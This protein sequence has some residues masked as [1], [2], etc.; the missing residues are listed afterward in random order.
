[1][2]SEWNALLHQLQRR[3]IRTIDVISILISD[4]IVLVGGYILI[5][6][7]ERFLRSGNRFIIGAREISGAAFMLIY[8]AW[9]FHDVWEFVKSS[10]E[11]G[12]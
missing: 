11:T 12:Q 2:S 3:L 7:A 8:V 6:V 1:V 9:V 4:A 10:R 5:V